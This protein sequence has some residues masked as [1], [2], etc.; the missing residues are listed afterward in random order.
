MPDQALAGVDASS[1]AG[2]CGPMAIGIGIE[3]S[4]IADYSPLSHDIP[5]GVIVTEAAVHRVPPP[6]AR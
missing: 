1:L 4:R 2:F 3:V 5:M 6:A